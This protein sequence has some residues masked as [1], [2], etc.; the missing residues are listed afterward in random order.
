MWQIWTFD[1]VRCPAP[2]DRYVSPFTLEYSMTSSYNKKAVTSLFKFFWRALKIKFCSKIE[3]IRVDNFIILLSEII[4]FSY[5][6]AGMVNQS[7]WSQELQW[8]T[9][10]NTKSNVIP[11]NHGFKLGINVIYK[12]EWLKSGFEFKFCIEL[13]LRRLQLVPHCCH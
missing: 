1:G 11:K 5:S 4:I 13:S 3:A 9:P 6:C 12:G 7:Y 10:S 8:S 2:I